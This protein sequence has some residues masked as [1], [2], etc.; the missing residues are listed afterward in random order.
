MSTFSP[1]LPP[2]N[3]QLFSLRPPPIYTNER[4]KGK[5]QRRTVGFPHPSARID[6]AAAAAVYPTTDTTS[7]TTPHHT[8]VH[9]YTA[10]RYVRMRRRGTWYKRDGGGRNIPT[11][12]TKAV[13]IRAIGTSWGLRLPLYTSYVPGGGGSCV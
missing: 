7:M 13:G 4:H 6:A 12:S 8:A 9:L 3:E 11:D 1:P 2:P 5:K 10:Y